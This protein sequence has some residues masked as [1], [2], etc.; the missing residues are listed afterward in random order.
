M[1]EITPYA[2]H[3]LGRFGELTLLCSSVSFVHSAT[4]GSTV[5]CFYLMACVLLDQVDWWLV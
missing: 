1:V 5:W 3:V 4:D 2:L